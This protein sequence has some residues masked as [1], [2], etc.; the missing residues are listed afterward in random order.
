MFKDLELKE[1]LGLVIICL[2]AAL[3]FYFYPSIIDVSDTERMQLVLSSKPEFYEDTDG[4]DYIKLVDSNFKRPFKITGC[5]LDLIDKENLL[6]LNSGSKLWVI[7]EYESLISDKTFINNY[8]LVYAIELSNG[9]KILNLSE[10]NSCKNNGWKPFAII[11]AI[12]IA[13][14]FMSLEKKLK[15]GSNKN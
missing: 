12:L 6:M 13:L 2:G 4:N 10:Y 9:K 1:N 15:K 11:G 5:S 14:L 8:I 3:W 7:S